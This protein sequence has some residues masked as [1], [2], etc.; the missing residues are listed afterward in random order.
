[1]GRNY[2]LKI[3]TTTQTFDQENQRLSRTPNGYNCDNN[4]TKLTNGYVFHNTYYPTLEEL[5]KHFYITYHIGKNSYGW[6][7][8]LASYPNLGVTKLDHWKELF[9]LGQIEDEDGNIISQEQMINIITKKES[10]T[11]LQFHPESIYSAPNETYD[12]VDH[13]DFS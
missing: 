4:Y 12:V 10:A 6:R 7:F 11:R 9:K 8:L 2:Y 5:D 3:K 1:M 13:Y